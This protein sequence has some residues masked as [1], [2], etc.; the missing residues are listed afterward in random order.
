M[1]TAPIRYDWT[2]CQRPKNGLSSLAL[3]E[4]SSQLQLARNNTLRDDLE[5]FQSRQTPSADLPPNAG[6]LELPERLLKAYKQDRKTSELGQILRVARD[7]R[8][9]LDRIVLLGVGESCIAAKAL[10]DACLHPYHNELSRSSR[11][12][13]P[14]IYFDG[15]NVD[16]DATQGLLELLRESNSREEAPWG[17]VVISLGD[18]AMEIEAAFRTFLRQLTDTCR[19]QK[20]DFAERVIPVTAKSGRLFELTQEIGC[21]ECFEVPGR[22]RERFSVLSVAGLLPSALMGIDVV[23]LLEGAAAMNEHF[24]STPPGQNVVLQYVGVCH[25]LEQAGHANLRIL[26]L[27]SD[28]LESLG[29]WHDQLMAGSLG[30]RKPGG[31]PLT[32]VNTRE[33]RSRAPQHQEGTRDNLIT[34]VVID[35]Y[36]CD[37]LTIGESNRIQDGS[38]GI[39]KRHYPDLMKAAFLAA[40]MSCQDNHRPTATIYLP[41]TD[42]YSLGQYFQMMML[43][44][45]VEARL[46]GVN[47]YEPPGV[48]S[49]RRHLNKNLRDLG[50]DF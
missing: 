18:G 40:N 24:R 29:R 3:E 2:G 19:G 17:I 14:R 37:L 13:V 7:W 48:E 9:K 44:A 34:N 49:Y 23:R 50:L 20:K 6:F 41:G 46:V 32:I 22:V 38:N 12:G 39:A 43:A 26:C 42:E 36:R 47:P 5:D 27:W 33:I 35:N 21:P 8:N 11:G 10:M 16:N 31:T 45:V 25:L 28:V 4:I 30:K 1:G 15:N